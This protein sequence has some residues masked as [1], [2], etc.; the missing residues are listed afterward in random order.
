MPMQFLKSYE[1]RILFFL[2]LLGC[3][4][5]F[6]GCHDAKIWVLEAAPVLLGIP[7]IAFYF[8]KFR[9]TPLLYRLLFLGSSML[10]VGAHYT[11]SRVPFGLWLQRTFFLKRNHYDRIGHFFQG[12]VPAI[13]AREVLLRKGVVR[14]GFWL[15]FIV[16][17]VCLAFSAYYEVLEWWAVAFKLDNSG[18]F[19]GAQGDMYDAQWDMFLAFVGSCMALVFL[20]EEHDYELSQVVGIKRKQY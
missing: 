2:T 13:L 7:F 17:C 18:D 8:K 14:H 6:I 4:V 1:P 5:S 20:S 16:V 15:S 19:M 9:F 10:L 11:Y 12:F 3:V